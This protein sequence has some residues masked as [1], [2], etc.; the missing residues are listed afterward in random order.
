MIVKQTGLRLSPQIQFAP[1]EMQTLR[2]ALS[3]VNQ[4][5]EELQ[6]GNIDAETDVDTAWLGLSEMIERINEHGG[7]DVIETAAATRSQP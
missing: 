3:L 6:C 1:T 4:A 5:R 2:R 7:L